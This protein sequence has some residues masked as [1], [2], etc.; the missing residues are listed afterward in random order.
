M[1]NERDIQAHRSPR[2]LAGEVA[3]HSQENPIYKQ[4]E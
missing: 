3:P 2:K 4:E 1:E